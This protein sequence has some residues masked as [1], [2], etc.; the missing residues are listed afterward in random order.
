MT[1]IHEHLLNHGPSRSSELTA[2][3]VERE[4]LSLQSARKRISRLPKDILRLHV[5]LPKGETF[6]CLKQQF[7]KPWFHSRLKDALKESGSAPGRALLG[8]EARGGFVEQ[9]NFPT[10]SGLP[11]KPTKKQL[12]HEVVEKRLL[13][14]GVIE[15]VVARNGP[16]ISMGGTVDRLRRRQAVVFV[17][18]VILLALREYFMRLGVLSQATTTIR[19]DEP[20]PEFGPFHRTWSGLKLSAT[21][22]HTCTHFRTPCIACT[23]IVRISPPAGTK[24][25]CPF[26]LY[27]AGMPQPTP[28]TSSETP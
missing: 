24:S 7:K 6:L 23:K 4:K 11:V 26:H 17:E 25:A 13:D 19:F 22:S 18:G 1:I 8:I 9:V 21:V 2:L 5:F 12:S 27:S 15:L 20:R 3:L 10:A 14:L 28:S 16:V